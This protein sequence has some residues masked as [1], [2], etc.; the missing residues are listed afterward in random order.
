[1]NR[2]LSLISLKSAAFDKELRQHFLC[3]PFCRLSSFCPPPYSS[4]WSLSRRSA[5]CRISVR[6]ALSVP[7]GCCLP[8]SQRSAVCSCRSTQERLVELERDLVLQ[9][10]TC[11]KELCVIRKS[12]QPL[13]FPLWKEEVNKGK[14]YSDYFG[15]TVSFQ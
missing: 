2:A 13:L 7:G 3:E 4:F 12:C 9:T 8:E 14:K 1:M 6:A 5:P 15:D 11:F 10:M